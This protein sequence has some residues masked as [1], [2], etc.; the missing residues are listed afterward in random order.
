[1]HKMWSLVLAITLYWILDLFCGGGSSQAMPHVCFGP[2]TY[3]QVKGFGHYQVHQDTHK[4]KGSSLGAPAYAIMYLV[5]ITHSKLVQS[6]SVYLVEKSSL[7]KARIIPI[8]HHTHFTVVV[9]VVKKMS[10]FL[11]SV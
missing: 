5:S 3:Y 7:Q 8:I 11:T 2:L 6:S 4:L 10:L 9:S 1:L